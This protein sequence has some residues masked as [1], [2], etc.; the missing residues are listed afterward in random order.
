MDDLGLVACLIRF[1]GGKR[2]NIK[3]TFPGYAQMPADFVNAYIYGS[4]LATLGYFYCACATYFFNLEKASTVINLAS[5][6]CYGGVAMQNYYTG[7]P[8]KAFRQW[9][10]SQKIPHCSP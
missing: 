8:L 3:A 4:V 5:F 7:N 6:G 2:T 1:N 10:P 9:V